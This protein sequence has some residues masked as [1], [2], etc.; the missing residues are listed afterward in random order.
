MLNKI[1]MKE[2]AYLRNGEEVIL[3]QILP[4]K[5]GFII[6][7]MYKYFD[8]DDNET[9]EP[10]GT[11]ECVEEVF[12]K[13]PIEKK[14][15]DLV[16]ITEQIN[17]K[18]EE[19]AMIQRSVLDY[20]RDVSNLKSTKT[21][22]KN[23]I[24]NRSELLS[25]KRLTVFCGYT[26]YDLKVGNKGGISLYYSIELNNGSISAWA[27]KIY[28]DGYTTAHESINEKYGILVDATDEEILEIGKQIVK[29]AKDIRDW[30]LKNKIPE[31]YLTE[32][33]KLRKKLLL[34]KEAKEEIESL[35]KDIERKQ[36]KISKLENI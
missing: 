31:E 24:I 9:F 27:Y 12:S 21:D 18:R 14:Q 30:D 1:K 11:K 28:E 7:R 20:E 19:L 29:D 33:L 32:E 8:Y 13:T 10:C 4:Q 25:A 23:H 3:H 36:L 22:L 6:E 16:D 2:T 17:A 5:K 15:Q 34:Q 35:K 26:P